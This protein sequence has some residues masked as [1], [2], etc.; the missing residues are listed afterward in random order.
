[1]GPVEV[2]T[3]ASRFP[4]RCSPR[5]SRIPSPACP[6][7]VAAVGTAVAERLVAA[8]DCPCARN[9]C[10]SSGWLKAAVP[11]SRPGKTHHSIYNSKTFDTTGCE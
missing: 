3:Q 1:M 5:S 11:S 8:A 10:G 9:C 7:A 2:D 6:S 4:T